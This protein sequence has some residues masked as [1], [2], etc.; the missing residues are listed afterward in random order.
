M[1][2]PRKRYDLLSVVLPIL[3][4][5]SL[6]VAAIVPVAWEPSPHP[7]WNW[8]LCTLG[9]LTILMPLLPRWLTAVRWHVAS[10]Q[11]VGTALAEATVDTAAGI[12]SSGAASVV[13]VLWI[14]GLLLLVVG[15]NLAATLELF[16]RLLSTVL[17][18]AALVFFTVAA[19][20][21]L[22]ILYALFV[23]PWASRSAGSEPSEERQHSNSTGSG[24]SEHFHRSSERQQNHTGQREQN[25]HSNDRP[26]SMPAS[27]DPYE[28]LQIRTDATKEDIHKAYR[29]QMSL[30][31]PDKFA[32]LGE[33]NRRSAEEKTKEINRAY[34]ILSKR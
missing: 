34:G 21:L 22:A 31:H 17:F 24:H 23:L 32:H 7:A 29:H 16:S 11:W 33:A 10:G 5:F 30:H 6:I 27:F 4:G 3:G 20:R 12:I 2:P 1:P 19:W 9:L 13:F 18:L 25:R 28:V 15:W 26:R 14:I 8:I